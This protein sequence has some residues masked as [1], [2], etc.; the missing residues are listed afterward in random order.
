MDFIK[1]YDVAG[2]S[3][4]IILQ[5]VE[6][7]SENVAVEVETSADFNGTTDSVELVQSNDRDLDLTK[8]HPLPE[9]ALIL[10]ADDSHLLSSFAFT[11]KFLAVRY[12]QA[13]G[14]TGTLTL[15]A[16]YKN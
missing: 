3:V 6:N 13:D 14:T 16:N 11:A 8:W 12:T 7:F 1:N 10:A 4:D 5:R 2:G 15:T 9:P